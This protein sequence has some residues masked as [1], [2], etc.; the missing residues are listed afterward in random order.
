MYSYQF[1]YSIFC[2]ETKLAV[3]KNLKTYSIG[4]GLEET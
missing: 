3:V 4:I 2:F 1:G